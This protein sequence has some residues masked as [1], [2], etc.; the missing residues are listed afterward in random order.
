MADK[1]TGKLFSWQV[2]GLTITLCGFA[3][4]GSDLV[5]VGLVEGR[6]QLNVSSSVVEVVMILRRLTHTI[7]TL[8]D[9]LYPNQVGN[10]H[11]LSKHWL[12][13]CTQI[14]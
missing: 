10:S 9:T 2:L 1:G 12:I 11:T 7:K 4:I 13:H 5:V 8:A 3:D 6:E 14:R